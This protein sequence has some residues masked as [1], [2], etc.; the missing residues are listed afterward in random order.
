MNNELIA[1]SERY[2]ER[3]LSTSLEALLHPID[4]SNPA[5][6]SVKGNGVYHTIQKARREDDPSLPLGPWEHKLKRADWPV[7]SRTAAQALQS[8]T[9][10]LQVAAWLLE[11]QVH[12]TGFSAIAPTLRLI[13]GLLGS[14]WQ[15]LYPQDSAT[16]GEHRANIL[17]SINK[18]LPLVLKQLFI[19]ASGSQREYSLVDRESAL[20]HEQALPSGPAAAATAMTVDEEA[21]ASM[22]LIAA[23]MAATPTT[24]YQALHL[25]LQDALSTLAELQTSMDARFTEDAP[26]LSALTGLLEQ[27]RALVETEL[28]R[29]GVHLLPMQCPEVQVDDP[30]V[31]CAENS[32]DAAPWKPATGVSHPM[33]DRVRAYALLEQATQVLLQIDPHSPTPYLVQRAIEWG[34]LNTAELYQEVFIR[35]G[36]QINI[37]ELLGLETPQIQAAE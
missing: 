21:P 9:K 35:L 5:G 33:V 3:Q 25:D 14:Y 30:P 37:F 29:R 36:G 1:R 28:Q 15:D 11:A 12:Q 19:T 34:R 2:F 16:G 18:K 13:N 23:A 31:N 10:D 7:V 6:Y 24:W 26:S 17:R 22:A 27:I 4:A 20:H 8:K 32:A